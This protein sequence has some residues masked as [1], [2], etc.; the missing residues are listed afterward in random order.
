MY[1]IGVYK[2]FG[3]CISINMGGFCRTA[4]MLL[5]Q[6]MK[7][8]GLQ[9]VEDQNEGCGNGDSFDILQ[10]GKRRTGFQPRK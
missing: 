10:A 6:D 8:K 1:G 5:L 2:C 7:D 3:F 9:L 4:G